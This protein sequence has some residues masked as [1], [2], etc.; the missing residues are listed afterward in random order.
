MGVRSDIVLEKGFFG[1]SARVVDGHGTTRRAE[2]VKRPDEGPRPH[3][4]PPKGVAGYTY[5]PTTHDPT[6]LPGY[7]EGRARS[8][9]TVTALRSG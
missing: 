3:H 6:V 1:K 7:H 2:V 4:P 9:T 5:S 8:V